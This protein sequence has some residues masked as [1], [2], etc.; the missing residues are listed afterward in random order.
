MPKQLLIDTPEKCPRCQQI[1]VCKAGN[2][3]NCQCS[4][5]SLN[6]DQT[7]YIRHRYTSCLCINCLKQL[8][9]EYLQAKL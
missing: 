5:I 4:S 7:D 6:K 2:I 3:G 8:Q 1:F 9:E